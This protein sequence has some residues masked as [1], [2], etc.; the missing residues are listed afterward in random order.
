[1]PVPEGLATPAQG[2]LRTT[3]LG[4][5]RIQVR[6]V[7]VTRVPVGHDMR[8]QVGRATPGLEEQ[9]AYVHRCADD[10]TVPRGDA[11]LTPQLNPLNKPRS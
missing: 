2:E 1:M 11:R 3:V 5:R 10:A 6:A 9:A 4:G 7:R 8:V